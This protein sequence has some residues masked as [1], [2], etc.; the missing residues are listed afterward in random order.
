MLEIPKWLAA[1]ALVLLLTLTSEYI[2][3]AKKLNV[4]KRS[5]FIVFLCSFN[6]KAKQELIDSGEER[7]L[8]VE[9]LIPYMLIEADMMGEYYTWLKRNSKKE[10]D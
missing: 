4:L 9:T 6:E 10:G 2:R 3:E 7:L 1:L 5:M 8:K